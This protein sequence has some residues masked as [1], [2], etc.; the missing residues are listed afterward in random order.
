[1][2]ELAGISRR[3]RVA[4]VGGRGLWGTLDWADVEFRQ[5]R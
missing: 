4:F 5:H 2:S 1:M 3:K